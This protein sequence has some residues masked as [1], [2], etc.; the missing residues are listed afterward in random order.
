MLFIDIHTDN[1]L[2]QFLENMPYGIH[3]CEC[4][5]CTLEYMAGPLLLCTQVD[6]SSHVQRSTVDYSRYQP[7]LVLATYR[8][9]SAELMIYS[10]L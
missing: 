4:C 8:K 7:L 5:T 6:A 10:T 2:A 9:C 1:V 3:G